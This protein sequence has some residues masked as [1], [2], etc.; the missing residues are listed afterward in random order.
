MTSPKKP[1]TR[2]LPLIIWA[3]IVLLVL[4]LFIRAVFNPQI[5]VTWEMEN[6]LD[7]TGYNLYRADSPEGEYVKINQAVIPPAQDP[8]LGGIYNHT[9]ED[10]EWFKT[11][12]YQLEMLNRRGQSERS[13]PMPLKATLTLL[14]PQ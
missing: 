1:L 10:V 11:Y 7:I 13:E 14:T 5:F 4:L 8:L 12:Y 6:E 2:N 9:D 3:A